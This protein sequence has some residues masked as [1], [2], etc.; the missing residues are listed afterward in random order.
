M[1]LL[2]S[3]IPRRC[4]T[5]LRRCSPRLW[6][7]E[8]VVARV[9]D[10]EDVTAVA[11]GAG[12]DVGRERV[13]RH[14]RVPLRN[15]L[16][17]LP[18]VVLVRHLQ[19]VDVEADPLQRRTVPRL[20]VAGA[21][22]L[23]VVRG[24]R[25][26]ADDPPCARQVPVVVAG[27]RQ[28]GLGALRNLDREGVDSPDHAAGVAPTDQLLV[29]R[30]RVVGVL[31]SPPRLEED[32]VLDGSLRWM[33]YQYRRLRSRWSA[34]ALEGHRRRRRPSAARGGGWTAAGT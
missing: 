23:D 9:A 33:R 12:E 32:R 21:L 16:G 11:E 34:P 29:D 10:L 27:A 26:V 30:T 25:V 19:V 17:E 28:H 24:H 2:S 18:Q 15:V 3:A 5:D 31:L 6:L 13:R 4:L 20:P 1:T 8:D 14:E 7:V 22:A